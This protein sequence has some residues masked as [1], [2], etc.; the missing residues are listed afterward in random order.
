MPFDYSDLEW[1]RDSR[2]TALL[3]TP[4]RVLV[5]RGIAMRDTNTVVGYLPCTQLTDVRSLP[6]APG[7][8]E[9]IELPAYL[10]SS[11]DQAAPRLARASAPPWESDTVRIQPAVP[12]LSLIAAGRAPT[13][14]LWR[15]AH[16]QPCSADPRASR[17]RL[18]N[19]LLLSLAMMASGGIA[20]ALTVEPALLTAITA[21][22]SL[23]R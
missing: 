6:A 14:P 16:V 12:P 10:L 18:G 22:I 7:A 19:V 5:A 23:P 3:G 20:F 13:D 17:G 4:V 21:A 9:P 8:P 1:L 2:Q 15:G 11:P